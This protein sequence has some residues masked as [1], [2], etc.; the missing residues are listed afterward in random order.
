[1]KSGADKKSHIQEHIHICMACDDNYAMH[2]AVTIASVVEN[3]SKNCFLHFYV[4]SSSLSLKNK[5]RLEKSLSRAAGEADIRF[6]DVKKNMFSNCP[7]RSDFHLTVETYFRLKMA[8]FF[9]E[10]DKIL[11][12]DSDVVVS[13]DISELWNMNI[14]GAY[15]ACVPNLYSN[16]YK[17]IFSEYVQF[18]ETFQYYNAGVMLVN[19][20]KWREDSIESAFFEYI[21][22]YGDTLLYADQDVLNCVINRNI[23]YLEDIWNA[24]FLGY[25]TIPDNAKVIHFI[26]GSKPWNTYL[27][28]P[29]YRLYYKY[30]KKTDWRPVIPCMKLKL[31]VKSR[32]SSLHN[33]A[34]LMKINLFYSQKRFFVWGASSFMEKLLSEYPAGFFKIDGFIDSD[35]QRQ[36]K[37]FCGC[38]IYSPDEISGLHPDIVVSGVVNNPNVENIIESTVKNSGASLIKGFFVKQR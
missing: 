4:M 17:K 11:Y 34:S 13:G 37:L 6:V 12:L 35:E 22:N 18:D 7:V 14:D 23:I 24:Q 19:L 29:E 36:G 31:F 38:K 10:L 2:C 30:L 21:Q 15:L 5:K 25:N 33:L 28:V 16:R 32:L 27:N 1:M 20:A 9:S 26:S 3:V 8:S